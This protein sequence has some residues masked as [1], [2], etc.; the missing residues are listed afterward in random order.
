[1]AAGTQPLALKLLVF[2]VTIADAGR[3]LTDGVAQRFTLPFGP[4]SGWRA[5]IRPVNASGIHFHYEASS[6]LLA[7][8]GRWPG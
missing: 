8:L 4:A 6:T 5:T 1:M 7:V 3:T 2:E